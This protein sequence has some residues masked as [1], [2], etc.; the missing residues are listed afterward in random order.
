MGACNSAAIRAAQN[1]KGPVNQP[2]FTFVIL[3]PVGL[4][5][6][7]ALTLRRNFAG[8]NRE[9]VHAFACKT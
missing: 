7:M 2:F 5:D 8:V 6:F 9:S 1:E 4:A 3:L